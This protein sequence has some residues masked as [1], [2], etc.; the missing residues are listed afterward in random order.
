MFYVI[1]WE[2]G[3]VKYLEGEYSEA[4]ELGYFYCDDEGAYTVYE[5]D[6]EEDYE[7]NI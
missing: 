4:L 5:Y 6:S 1:E 7:A 2:S 3:M